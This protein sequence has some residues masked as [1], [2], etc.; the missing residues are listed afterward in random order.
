MDEKLSKGYLEKLQKQAKTVLENNERPNKIASLGG[1]FSESVRSLRFILC[2][3][4]N[5]LFALLQLVSIA[6]CY[7]LWIQILNWIPEDV[8]KEV[9]KEDREHGGLIDLAVLAWGFICVGVAA[10]P[11]GILTSCI[12]AS[13]LLRF[14]G[15]KSTVLDCLKIAMHHA[16]T[17]WFFSW[18]DGW[19]TVMRILERLPKKN[20]KTPLSTKI[21]NELIYQAWKLVSLGF[22]PAIIGGRAVKDAGSDSLG[23]LK[24]RFVNVAKLRFGYSAICWIIGIS[25]YILSIIFMIHAPANIFP[26][27]NGIYNFYFLIG[28]PML[29]SLAVIMLFFRPLY[30]ISACRIYVNYA[31]DNNIHLDLPKKSP[32]ILSSLLAFAILCLIAAGIVYFRRELGIA[33][34]LANAEYL[35]KLW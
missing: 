14:S 34:I 9:G 35:H 22:L 28:I 13:F 12:C 1:F 6:L 3:K 16:K 19:W 27:T 4:E 24:K 31:R 11:I 10:F 7:Y 2:E 5:F 32:A 15:R 18:V 30:L 20:D 8:W 17:V 33:D 25:S 23:M 29:F 26:E 21:R